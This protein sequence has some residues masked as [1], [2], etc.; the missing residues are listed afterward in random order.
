M[1]IR[2][3]KRHRFTVIDNR[4]LR[5]N[6]LSWAARGLLAYLLSK[7]HNWKLRVSNLVKESPAKRDANYNLISELAAHRYIVRFKI[8]DN[9]TGRFTFDAV[10]S[11]YPLSDDEIQKLLAEIP[12]DEDPVQEL[13][14]EEVPEAG[15]PDTARPEMAKPD[16]K[17]DRSKEVLNNEKRSRRRTEPETKQQYDAVIRRVFS[18]W[19]ETF[20]HVLATGQYTLTAKKHDMLR[21]RLLG[22]LKPTEQDCKNA[23]TAILHTPFNMGNNERRE[24]Y[25]KWHNAF[26]DDDTLEKRLLDYKLIEG[27]LKDLEIEQ[28]AKTCQYCEGRGELLRMPKTPDGLTAV[29]DNVWSKTLESIAKKIQ[30][31][32]FERWFKPVVCAGVNC[33]AVYLTVSNSIAQ[34][35]IVAN[36]SEALFVSIAESFGKPFKVEWLVGRMVPCTHGVP[37]VK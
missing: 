5:D 14:F 26:Q 22:P 4:L 21:D 15:Q 1:I 18:F 28:A 9:K 30:P 3:L 23:I 13:P 2:V 27:K 32:T 16:H 31:E 10:V 34:E 35:W 29:P 7:P 17:K 24:F 37:L 12:L 25:C 36:H 6:R 8:K 19:Q 33:E 11:E 20:K